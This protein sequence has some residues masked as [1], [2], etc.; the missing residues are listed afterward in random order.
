[1]SCHWLCVLG[2]RF[3]NG[4]CKLAHK[5]DSVFS[6]GST[7]PEFRSSLLVLMCV[8]PEGRDLLS[9]PGLLSTCWH[10][11][12]S[13]C[14][15]DQSPPMVI[16]PIWTVEMLLTRRMWPWHFQLRTAMRASLP[17]HALHFPLTTPL[18][19]RGF[20]LPLLVGRDVSCLIS[21]SFPRWHSPFTGAG[22]QKG[23]G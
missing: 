18:P 12:T 16:Y 9:T 5:D 6:V 7:S 8:T 10:L 23:C 14:L 2:D 22:R 15:Q 13:L 4:Y 20:P 19:G 17:G 21:P 1:M 11:L 3:G